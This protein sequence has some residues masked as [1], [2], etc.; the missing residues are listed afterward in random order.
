MT[1]DYRSNI[2]PRSVYF[3]VN[4]S[5]EVKRLGGTSDRLAVKIELDNVLS[6]HERGRLA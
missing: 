6:R 3:A 1:V 5:L 4:E 2:R